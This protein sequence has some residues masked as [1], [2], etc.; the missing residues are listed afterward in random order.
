MNQRN[1]LVLSRFTQRQLTRHTE[2][3]AYLSALRQEASVVGMRV[4]HVAKGWVLKELIWTDELLV[5]RQKQGR[6]TPEL[7]QAVFDQFDFFL[8]DVG[9]IV[10]EAFYRIQHVLADASV[11]PAV[12]RLA[13]TL[14]A[15]YLLVDGK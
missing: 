14:D 8:R 4:S 7:E 12:G 11:D 1:D 15:C 2:Q 9:W 10:S 6:L 3:M 5:E 13:A